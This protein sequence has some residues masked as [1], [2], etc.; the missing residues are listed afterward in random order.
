MIEFIVILAVLAVVV[1]ALVAIISPII[2]SGIDAT[3]T[4]GGL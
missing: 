2:N 1:I 3:V 4:L